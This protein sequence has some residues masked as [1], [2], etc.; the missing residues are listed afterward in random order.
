MED[1]LKIKSY[2]SNLDFTKIGSVENLL[3]VIEDRRVLEE[4]HQSYGDDLS[5]SSSPEFELLKEKYVG[6]CC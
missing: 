2:L 3:D 4:L 1:L 5:I 6:I